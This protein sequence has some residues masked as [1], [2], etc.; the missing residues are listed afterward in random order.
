MPGPLAERP[1]PAGEDPDIFIKISLDIYQIFLLPVTCPVA[2]FA[3]F[4]S[5]YRHKKRNVH[6][7]PN[8][9]IVTAE[10]SGTKISKDTRPHTYDLMCYAHTQLT[11]SLFCDTHM[12]RQLYTI[13][14]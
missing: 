4:F 8:A 7:L 6:L 9:D 10:S 2:A 12:D 5:P 1:E 14:I 11:P 13:T 3:Y